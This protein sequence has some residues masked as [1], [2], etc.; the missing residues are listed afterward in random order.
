MQVTLECSARS[1]GQPQVATR[2]KR[3]D[4]HAVADLDSGFGPAQTFRMADAGDVS[5]PAGAGLVA[6]GTS[7]PAWAF[8]GRLPELGE[9]S[10]VL[11]GAAGGRGGALPGPG[12]GRLCGGLGEAAAGR[13]GP[14]L[15]TG[16]PGIGK[17]RLMEEFAGLLADQ[18][19]RV[20]A[21]R[22]RGRGGDP[23]SSARIHGVR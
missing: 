19:W 23:A 16:E 11:A 6:A 22:W 14:F 20:L 8:V 13:G 10:G 4:L 12:G 3:R 5:R 15:V 2:D 18:G 17:S 1:S 21:G 9:L 7:E